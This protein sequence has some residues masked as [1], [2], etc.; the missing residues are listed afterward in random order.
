ME[1]VHVEPFGQDQKILHHCLVC[2]H[3]QRNK[4]VPEDDFEA[5]LKLQEAANRKKFYLGK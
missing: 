1:P 3:E 5:V 2:G 4:I